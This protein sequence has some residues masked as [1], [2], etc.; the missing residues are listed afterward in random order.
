ML[1]LVFFSYITAPT[2]DVQ[3]YVS[4]NNNYNN[5]IFLT[6]KISLIMINNY[7]LHNYYYRYLYH[8]YS[9]NYT[10]PINE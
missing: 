1:Y 3:I 7:M 2:A 8:Y 5:K 10:F 9:I 4:S 6:L